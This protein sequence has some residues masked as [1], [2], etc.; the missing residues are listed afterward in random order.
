MNAQRMISTTR[1]AVAT[2]A[3]LLLA[4]CASDGTAKLNRHEGVMRNNAEY[5]SAVEHIAQR[6]GVRI[7]W[8]NPPEKRT[9]GL[10]TDRE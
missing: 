8:M 1:I 7:V 10:V 6:R 3:W 5:M 4:G 9:K 2:T